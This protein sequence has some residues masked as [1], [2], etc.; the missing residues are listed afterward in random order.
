MKIAILTGSERPIPA[1]RG[2]ATQTMM[3]HLLDQNE[4]EKKMHIT[5]FSYFEVEAYKDSKNYNSATFFYYKKN[6]LWD[7]LYAI[8]F[9]LLRKITCG[10]SYIK[11]NF[12]RFCIGEI[13]KDKFDAVI[14]EGNYFQVLQLKK[15]IDSN[16]IL[17]MHIDGLH[18]GTDN[19]INILNACKGVFA[20]SDYCRNR[21]LEIDL[22]NSDK[23][24]TI[25]N[26]IDT[27]LFSSDK[28]DQFRDDFR[29]QKTISNSQK[30]IFYCG[31][32]DETKGVFELIEA[33]KML[34]DT[35]IVLL[36]IGSSAY[37]DGK[38]TKLILMVVTRLLF[39]QK[40]LQI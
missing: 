38:K 9:R 30:V 23:I 5:V 20:I 7:K 32:I 2:G 19:G 15:G 14:V 1:T 11:T 12:V 24:I 13:V 6:E 31:R 35:S 10:K 36:I 8:P 40:Y 22:V 21:I 18:I 33:F 37:L 17:H 28:H 34:E 26:T 29:K 25:K 3:T 4:K 27:E 39:C 16:I